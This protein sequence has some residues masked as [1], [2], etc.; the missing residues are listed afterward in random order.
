[1]KNQLFSALVLGLAAL[2]LCGLASGA[3]YP[4]TITDTAGREVTFTQPIERIIVTSSDAAEAVVMLGSA[5]KVVG[6]SETL[7]NKGYYFPYLKDKQSVGKWNALDYEMIGEVASDGEDDVVP[8]IVVIGYSYPDK[9]YGIFGL[10]KGLEPFE[11]IK[12]VALEFTKPENMTREIEILGQI[13]GKEEQASDYINWYDQKMN[14]VE[15]SVDGLNMPKIYV[16]WS[17][18]TD[19]STLGAGSGFDQVLSVANGYN[20]AKKLGDAYPKVGWEWVITQN[21]EIIIKRQTQSSDQ[22]EIGWQSG[23]SKDTV[24]LQAVKN[25]LLARSGAS[26]ISAVKSDKVYV[27]DWDVL[28]GLDQVVGIT[29]LAK[30]LHPEADLD[31]VSVHRDYLKRLGL[32]YPEGRT[33]VYPELSSEE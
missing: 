1:M 9:S 23:P 7:K 11:N 22:K 21:P 20:I 16:E 14:S 6:I 33:L 2:L 30:L 18:A 5:D 10:E 26:G 13:L 31:P 17:S 25:E 29:Y 4:L 32:E 15:Q 8:D 24:K 27:M 28:N 3:E 19:L 12:A